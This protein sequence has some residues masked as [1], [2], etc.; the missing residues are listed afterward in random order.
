MEIVNQI[1]QFLSKI[2]NWWVI[3]MPW[4]QAVFVRAGKNSKKITKGMYLKVPFLDSVYIQTV[5][6]RMI[7][8]P[9][10]T[11][12]TKDGQAITIRSVVG[13]SIKDIE[14]LYNTI[15]HPEMTIQGLVMSKI[16]EYINARTS[17]D[18]NIKE[19]EGIIS[20]EVSKEDY[21][22][23]DIN[24]NITNFAIVKTFR[25]IQDQSWVSEGLEMKNGK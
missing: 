25:L 23:S 9:V 17:K 13:Y 16:G 19:L 1:I 6:K 8:M 12:S 2:F 4:E 24:V 5:R 15:S 18:I 3:I 7:D 21:G 20:N 10:Q 11:M 14:K 22:L